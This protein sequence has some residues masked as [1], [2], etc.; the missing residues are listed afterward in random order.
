MPKLIDLT[1]ERF[2]RLQ[3]IKRYGIDNQKKPTWLCKCDCG[4]EKIVSGKRLRE[5]KTKSCG[6]LSLDTL[7]NYNRTK[8]K[9]RPGDNING[10][11]IKEIYFE[12]GEG[13]AKAVCQ[14]C[15]KDFIVSLTHLKTGH[16]RSC[17]CFNSSY[18]EKQIEMLLIKHN[19]Q[20]EKEKSFSD[21]K[22]EQNNSRPRF[23]FF[24]NNQYIIEYDGIQHFISNGG[25]NTE[26]AVKL[27][28]KRDKIKNNYCFQ[29]NIPIIRIPYY[30]QN[31]VLED[32]LL[33]T[34][35]YLLK[36]GEEANVD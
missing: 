32:L 36:H 6:C 18:G 35:N 16:T 8:T 13:K 19:I 3:V 17:G 28:K 34:T 31:I 10:T 20:F 11:I 14:Y 33:E 23:D 25:W 5:G 7:T 21:L 30:H 4:N 27:N 24:V 9:E 29:N 26:N 1:N 2:G 15:G 12:N 22:Y